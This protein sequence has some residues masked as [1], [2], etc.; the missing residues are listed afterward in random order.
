MSDNKAF[1]KR[2]EEEVDAFFDLWKRKRGLAIG[3]IIILLFFAIWGILN[4]YG[5]GEKIEKLEKYNKELVS[6]LKSIRTENKSLRE[7]VTPLLKQAA[8]KFPGEEINVS[9][10]KLISLLQDKDPYDQPMRTATATVEVTIESDEEVD[11]T[12]ITVGGY[13]AFCKGEEVL[14]VMSGTSCRMQQK[15]NGQVFYSSICTMYADNLAS[16]KP[17]SFLREAEYAQIA[18]APM[19][20]NSKIIMG[21][22]VCV[23][24]N[25]E[26]IKIEIP[27]QQM[28]NEK[29]FVRNLGK[30]F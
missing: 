4:W 9:L 28:E 3:G 30:I 10:K 22:A 2:T 11:S 5:R 7:T 12:C 19:P 23:F 15:G 29:I 13:I 26:R 8:E 24:N 6:E 25:Q 20:P 21:K 27:P 16:G 14:I 18:F 17:L 1:F